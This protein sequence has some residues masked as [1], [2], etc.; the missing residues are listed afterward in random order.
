MKEIIRNE[1][2]P[3]QKEAIIKRWR[4]SKLNSIKTIA[5][6]FDCSQN[7]VHTIINKYLSTKIRS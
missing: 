3:D 1:L 2:T 7:R 4:T 5:E 6:E